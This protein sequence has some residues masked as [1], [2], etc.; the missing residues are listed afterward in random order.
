MG[1]RGSRLITYNNYDS[2]GEAKKND[3]E[4]PSIE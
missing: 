2:N 4:G 3:K 1:Y